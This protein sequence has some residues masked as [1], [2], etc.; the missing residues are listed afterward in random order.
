MTQFVALVHETLFSVPAALATTDQL[1]PFHC[2]TDVPTAR[3]LAALVH[4]TALKELRVAPI[5]LALVTIDQ[6][7]P[8]HSS[9]N[10]VTTPLTSRLPTAKQLVA[11]P[12]D[13]PYRLTPLTPIGF[14]LATT[15]QLEPFHCSINVDPPTTSV[16]PT[17]KQF[18]ALVH[19]IEAKNE[20]DAGLGLGTIDQLEPFHCSINVPTFQE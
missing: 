1:E 20:L 18:V 9:T 3:Q 5:G 17:A 6:L 19:D 7:E 15:D 16:P 11:L 10:V 12:H 2:C 8:F 13:T 4:D 14:G